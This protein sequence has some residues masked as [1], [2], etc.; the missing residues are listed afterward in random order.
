MA[1]PT[2]P[3]S[4]RQVQS[5]NS[6]VFAFVK[7]LAKEE[8][9]STLQPAPNNPFIHEK[10]QPSHNNQISTVKKM[11]N[12][13]ENLKKN[14]ESF[15]KVLE[16]DSAVKKK[17]LY[18]VELLTSWKDRFIG[19]GLLELDAQYSADVKTDAATPSVEFVDTSIQQKDKDLINQ[20]VDVL[21]L[22]DW[23]AYKNI[24]Q[25]HKEKFDSPTAYLKT[26]LKTILT[27]KNRTI[28]KLKEYT[29]LH[30][31]ACKKVG[32]SSKMKKV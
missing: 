2:N 30:K 21:D 4:N 31:E 6:D 18:N 19:S 11:I 9:K 28:E 5:E 15:L 10:F 25:V 3:T 13:S 20:L 12:T 8:G 26:F 1:S 17:F 29:S 27:Q 22:K 32:A 16:L 24:S 14:L 23:N 7:Q